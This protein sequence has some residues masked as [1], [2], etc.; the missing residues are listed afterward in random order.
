M[1]VLRRI[2]MAISGTVV[3]ALV[4]TLAVPKAAHAV[5]SA[6]VT[7]TN[8]PANPVPVDVNADARASIALLGSQQLDDGSSSGT[9]ALLNASDLSQ[10][11]IPNGKRFIIDDVNASV[12]VSP[13]SQPVVV[14]LLNQGNGH[15]YF[16][17]VPLTVEEPSSIPGQSDS[18]FAQEKARLFVDPGGSFQ[19]LFERNNSSGSANANVSVVG[20]LIDCGAGCAGQ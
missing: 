14:L 4:L 12:F 15:K 5:F 9:Q 6:L 10:F 7:V 3:V 17:Y 16:S 18:Y 13:G 19:V 11:V 1:T 2:A 8:T 20:H